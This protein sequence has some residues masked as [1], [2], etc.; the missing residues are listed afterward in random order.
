MRLDNRTIAWCRFL[1]LVGTVLGAGGCGSSAPK[2]PDVPLSPVTGKITVEGTP[3]TVGV[4]TFYPNQAQGNKNIVVPTG[5]IKDGEYKMQTNGKDG[6]PPGWY[7]VTISANSPTVAI[8]P[9]DA[10][11]PNDSYQN[12]M[13]SELQVDVKETPPP[14]GYNFNLTK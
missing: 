12:K 13:M 9:A 10:V 7:K 4:V 3:M 11:K 8:L 5:M 2:G 6:A 14:S 1:L